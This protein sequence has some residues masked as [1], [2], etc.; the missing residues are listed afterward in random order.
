MSEKKEAE[1]SQTYEV[2]RFDRPGPPLGIRLLWKGI[3]TEKQAIKNW[4]YYL[5]EHKKAKLLLV[6]TQ[7]TKIKP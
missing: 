1:M 5:K 4:K 7:R 2:V 3:C 6:I